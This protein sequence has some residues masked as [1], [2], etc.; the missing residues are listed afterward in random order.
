MQVRSSDQLLEW[1]LAEKEHLQRI[2]K[3]LPLPDNYD[4]L[5]LTLDALSPKVEAL[6][7]FLVSEASPDLT[8]LV[9]VEQRIWVAALAELV[10]IHPKLQGKLS[11]G[12]FV[13]NSMSSKRKLSIAVLVEPKNQQDTLDKFKSGDTNLIITTSVLEEGIDVSECHL[14]V[15]FERPKNVKSFVQRRG[16]ARRVQSKYIIFSA[17][18]GNERAPATW[19]KLEQEMKDAYEDDLR[20]VKET[21]E[22]ESVEEAGERLYEVATTGYV[23]FAMTFHIICS[24]YRS[25]LTDILVLYSRSTMPSHIS[26]ISAPFSAPVHTSIQDQSSP[27]KKRT[28]TSQLRSHSHFLS[29]PRYE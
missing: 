12:T 8:G 24:C 15:C 2:F 25:K 13:G 28:A 29:T 1:S 22:N 6:I 23:L 7:E 21:E 3:Q 4:S 9:F 14:V 20:H 5:P 17:I 18:E 26:I 10:S 27:S 16:R 11:I 19:E